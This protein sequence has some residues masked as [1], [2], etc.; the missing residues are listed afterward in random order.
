MTWLESSLRWYAVLAVCTWALAPWVRW[1]CPGLADRGATLARPIA[2][3]AAIYPAWLVASL[4]LAPYG[5][6]AVV[7]TVLVAGITGWGVLMRRRDLERGWLLGLIVAEAASLALFFAYVWLR[8]FTPEILGTE[9]PMDMAFLASST[10]TVTIPPPDPWFAGEPINYY[11]LG[12]L[13]HGTVARIAGVLPEIGFNLALASTFSMAM[14]ATFGVAWNVAR[15]RFPRRL[16]A[17]AGGLAAFGL[18]IAGNLYAPWR[19]TQNA[20]ET[21]DAWWWDSAIGIG[22]RSSR[23]V[24]D[25]PRIGARCEFPSIETINEFPY[26]SFLLGDLHPHLL[27]LPFTIVVLGLAWNL[28]SPRSAA[29]RE[30]GVAW[31]LLILLTGGIAGAL[32]ALNTWDFPISFIVLALG[33]WASVGYAVT[34]WKPIV[35]MAGGA[36]AAWLPFLAVYDAPTASGAALP[37]WLE[38]LPI[39]SDAFSSVALHLGDRTSAAEYLTIFGAPYMVGI[40][41]LATGAAGMVNPDQHGDRRGLVIALLGLILAAT[42]LSAPIVAL[43]GIPLAIAMAQIRS[44]PAPGPRTFALAAFGLAWILSIVVEIFYIRDAFDN[45]MNT[46]F[47]FYFQAWT[48][49]ALAAALAFVWLWRQSRSRSVPRALLATAGVMAIVAGLAYPLVATYQWTDKFAAW[50]GLDGLAYGETTDPGDTAAI[51]WLAAHA[52]PGDVL[53]EVAGCS[54]RPFGRLP[55]NRFA[56]FTGVPAVIG[57]GDNHQRQWRAGQPDLLAEIPRRQGDVVAMYD[58]PESALF[59]RYNIR[60]L[61]IGEYERGL[62]RSECAT[63]GPY[64][65]IS[66]PGFPGSGWEEVFRAGETRIYRAI[67]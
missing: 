2:L 62:W 31:S 14:V 56:A 33:A 67:S 22:W 17:L 35:M 58:D 51:R 40:V 48:L 25:G 5:S 42:L 18:V 66:D 12:Y 44:E 13:I 16:A 43:C 3:L 15:S 20:R 46:L 32:L 19:L 29:A 49:Y 61:I 21:I 24:C 50:Q 52:Q 59:A 26:F 57:W 39:L 65:G 8:G 37:A 55:F 63:A 36:M 30:R 6:T 45:R 4:H 23:I 28:A 38:T 34:V 41:L 53:L 7:G 10:R 11:Y 27:A 9:K 1:L 60:W 64:A 47:K 54:Y